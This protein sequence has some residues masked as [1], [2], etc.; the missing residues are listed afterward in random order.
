MNTTTDFILRCIRLV[1]LLASILVFSAEDSIGQEVD[2]DL[3]AEDLIVG[4]QRYYRDVAKG[5]KFQVGDD[6][7]S[8]LSWVEKPVLTYTNP[9]RGRQQHGAIFVWTDKGRPAAMASIW[10]ITNLRSPELR[11]TAH[12]LVSLSSMHLVAM[13]PS[14]ETLRPG[15]APEWSTDDSGVPWSELK[16]PGSR[17]GKLSTSRASLQ[18]R[19]LARRFRAELV[20][21]SDRSLNQLRMLEAPIFQYET[22][23]KE[24]IGG[25]F[26]FALA[27]DP[28]LILWLEYQQSSNPQTEGK[29][30]Y[31]PVRMSLLE[32][33]LY[34]DDAMVWTE[35]DQKEKPN[36][37][38]NASFRVREFPADKPP[39]SD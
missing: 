5:Y 26:A 29:W 18:M 3:A 32:L 19:R 8:D 31:R 34:L 6:T 36:A 9:V 23:S 25:L 21:R 11:V 28:E 17:G 12:E 38:Y 30:Q 15:V 24:R 14:P 33:K 39:T 4:W 35:L 7:R 13:R 1:C 22:E 16:L 37:T 20:T 10:S 27:T 2:S